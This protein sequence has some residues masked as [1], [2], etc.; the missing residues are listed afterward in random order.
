MT[1]R[2]LLA[3][4]AGLAA[5]EPLRLKSKVRVAII[6]VEGHPSEITKPLG[7]LPDVEVVAVADPDTAAL[8]RFVRG[9]IAGAKKYS[10]YRTMLDT[11]RP[12]VAAVCNSD[13]ERAA[14][15]VECANRKM[16]VM[17]E[18][19][20]GVSREELARVKQ[21]VARNGVQLGMLLPLR[22]DPPYLALRD[23]VKSGK[24][25]EVMQMSSQKS[26]QLGER[27]DWYHHR[28]TYGST[29]LWI[30]PHMIDLMRFTSGRDFTEVSSFA[31]VIAQGAMETST[32]SAFRLDN[33]G[34]AALHM[35]YY[36]PRSAGSHGDDRL[37]IA[38][39][40][41]VA[42]YMAATGVTLATDTVKPHRLEN[43]P[44]GGSVFRDFIAQVYAGAAPTLPLH[45]IY[46]VCEV[47]IAAHEAAVQGKVVKCNA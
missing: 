28:E 7:E 14:A 34:A 44:A 22:Y 1:R 23:I 25:G 3:G 47:T 29:I 30:G 24:I 40:K 10:D 35:D 5:A 19:P 38:G 37:R 6:G 32:A 17:S 8:T 16:H 26:Y 27:E 36:Y 2:G 18:K 43:L 45:D 42:E 31:G 33:G 41:G 15:V 12:D 13:G 20:L 4:V 46:R 9:R 39:T 21:A 11:E